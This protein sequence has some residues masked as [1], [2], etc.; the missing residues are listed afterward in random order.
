MLKIRGDKSFRVIL[1]KDA[2]RRGMSPETLAWTILARYS[3][4]IGIKE[5]FKA[6]NKDTKNP[7]GAS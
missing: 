6:L 3:M 2:E 1:D 5:P 7:A 4:D